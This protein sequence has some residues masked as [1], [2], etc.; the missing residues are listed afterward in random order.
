MASEKRNI[1]DI[2]TELAMRVARSYYKEHYI[3]AMDLLAMKGAI[4]EEDM[5]LSLRLSPVDTRK[6]CKK[7]EFDRL[8]KSKSTIQEIKHFKHTKRTTKT[9]YY[10][11][12]KS[13][14]NVIKYRM[15]KIQ[16]II[17]KEI[18][19]HNNNLAYECPTCHTKFDPF[20][21]LR[22]M[23]PS[24][25]MFVCEHCPDGVVLDQEKG[26]DFENDLSRR[27]NQ[28]RAPI[29]HL[30]QLT[31]QQVIPEFQ[32]PS[33]ESMNATAVDATPSGGLIAPSSV[34]IEIH[35]L[36][37]DDEESPSQGG[38]SDMKGEF[39][40][41]GFPIADS[42]ALDSKDFMMQE[43]YARLQTQVGGGGSSSSGFGGGAAVGGSPAWSFASD[44]SVGGASSGSGSN[45]RDAAAVEQE[46]EEARKRARIV[47]AAAA[48]AP[49]VED[50]SDLDN[51]EFVEI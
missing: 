2:L 10:I 44:T 4:R 18:D 41:E 35:G 25:G 3:M 12:Y 42:S 46:D 23:R 40:D 28:E 20:A 5:A 15:F 19:E 13:L 32:P 11:D 9:Y 22:L 21:V 7:L 27:F 31:D 49:V 50:D 26:T 30:L 48:L 14:L 6:L 36:N 1:K 16:E 45:K 8:V 38:G 39:D 51:E 17:R 33:V 47:A 24:D 43:Y 29:L 37:E 34:K